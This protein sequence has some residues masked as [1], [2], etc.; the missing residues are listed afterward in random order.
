[1]TEY[2]ITAL[3]ISANSPAEYRGATLASMLPFLLYQLPRDD[4]EDHSDNVVSIANKWNNMFTASPSNSVLNED[5]VS[6]A[7][8]A[9]LATAL[10]ST[11]SRFPLT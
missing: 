3:L 2:A 4:H 6:I 1:M 9:P 7:N 5:V 11:L 10:A 8:H